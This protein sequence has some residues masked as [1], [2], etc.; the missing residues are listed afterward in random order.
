[1]P[2]GLTGLR[3]AH[4]T[5]LAGNIDNGTTLRIATRGVGR[6]GL[7]FQHRGNL[8]PRGQPAR[9]VVDVVDGIE[10]CQALLRGAHV[11]AEDP[12]AV[13]RVVDP[14]EPVDDGADERVH[15]RRV[16]DVA[17]QGKDLDVGRDVLDC[18]LALRQQVRLPVCDGDS[19]AAFLCKGDGG[20]CTDT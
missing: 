7:L 19:A 13:D 1:M 18:L 4:Y 11:A 9:P 8:C 5:E 15:K 3:S 10:S 2:D 17:G 20:V 16:R 12:G 6:Q 14:S